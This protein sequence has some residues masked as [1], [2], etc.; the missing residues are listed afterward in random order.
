MVEK[1]MVRE[2]E[3]ESTDGFEYERKVD[4]YK[5]VIERGRTGKK[6]VHGKDIPWSFS[7]QGIARHYL[8]FYKTENAL[9]TMRFFVHDVRTHS[10][11]HV[12]QGD[13][14]LFILRGKG[15]TVVDDKTFD[16]SEGDLILLPVKKGGVVHQHFNKDGKPSRWLAMRSLPLTELFGN[17]I[18]QK[19]TSPWWKGKS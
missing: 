19:E 10:G 17:F 12:H 8:D 7:R 6:V 16:W 18:E 3:A 9:T 13:I 11:K 15:Y 5:Q 1:E 4:Y 2:R 14:V